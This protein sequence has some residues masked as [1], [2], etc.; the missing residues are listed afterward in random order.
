[1]RDRYLIPL[2]VTPRHL[3]L[4]HFTPRH[5]TFMFSS[6]VLVCHVPWYVSSCSCISSCSCVVSC[7]CVALVSCSCPCIHAPRAHAPRAH[8]QAPR[9]HAHAP[10]AHAPRAHALLPVSLLVDSCYPASIVLSLVPGF[11]PWFCL[12]TACL[13]LLLNPFSVTLCVWVLPSFFTP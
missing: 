8:A 5:F 2:H 9:A 3:I 12:C 6:L 10:R 13:V 1:M 4:P 7:S 11:V